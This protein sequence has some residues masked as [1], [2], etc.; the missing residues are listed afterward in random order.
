MKFFSGFCKT[1]KKLTKKFGFDL[2][3]K[4]AD[5]QK[6]IFTTIATDINVTIS[7]F[8]LYVPIF[9]PIAE[10]Q[11]MFNES[12]ENNFTPSFESWYTYRNFANVGLEF[13]TDIGSAQNVFAP[14]YLIAAH[15]TAN[16][17]NA[18]NKARNI[19]VFDKVAAIKNVFE[20]DGQRYPK[21]AS[22]LIMRKIFI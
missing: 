2:T 11:I 5:L 15:Q 12:I 6:I 4:T 16:R 10:T 1:C 3:F 13:L 7:S 22:N 8:Y 21:D 9:T 20:I 17:I 19:A 14:K 18:P